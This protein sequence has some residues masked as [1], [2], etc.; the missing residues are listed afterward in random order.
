[1]KLFSA[2]IEDLRSLYIDNLQKALDME[3]KITK[4]LPDLIAKSTDPDL[5]AAFRNHLQETEGHVMKV[6]T[7]LRQINNDDVS[8]VTCKV[9]GALTTEASDTIKDVTDPSVR[10]VAIIGAAQ[11]VEHH[12]IAVYG[13]LRSWAELLGL[14]DDADVLESILREEKNANDLLTDLSD[15]INTVAEISK[16]GSAR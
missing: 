11:Q 9:I 10:D 15:N 3:E 14:E 7:L 6:E 16:V 2:N 5:A 12:E 4:A 1:M 8:T 13:T